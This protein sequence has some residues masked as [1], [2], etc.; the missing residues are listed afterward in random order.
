MEQ[1][2]DIPLKIPRIIHQ[3]WRNGSIPDH[4]KVF[5][6]TWSGGV[7]MDGEKYTYKL[8][9]DESTEAFLQ[10]HY[11]WFIDTYRSYPWNIQRVDA[12]R[13]FWLYHYGND[14][15]LVHLDSHL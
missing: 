10:E 8:W 3:T 14:N 7:W 13:Y 5:T 2:L 11:P 12:A 6:D 9:T 15:I 1:K 4:W